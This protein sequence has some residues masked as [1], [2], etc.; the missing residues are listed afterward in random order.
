MCIHQKLKKKSLKKNIY[1]KSIRF[2]EITI[3]HMTTP[4]DTGLSDGLCVY[5]VFT[6]IIRSFNNMACDVPAG[7]FTHSTAKLY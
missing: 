3:D 7:H 1:I 4:T 2:C 5:S 6:K